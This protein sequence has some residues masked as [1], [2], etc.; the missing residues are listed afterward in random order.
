MLTLT[1]SRIEILLKIGETLGKVHTGISTVDV[2]GKIGVL[3][4]S[5]V[6]I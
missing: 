1:K 3:S 5:K 2:L 4:A 6:K